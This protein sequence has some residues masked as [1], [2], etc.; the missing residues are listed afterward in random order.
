MSKAPDAFQGMKDLWGFHKEVHEDDWNDGQQLTIKVKNS[1]KS[2][3][4]WISLFFIK[5]RDLI[6]CLDSRIF[7]S[8]MLNKNLFS[9]ELRHYFEIRSPSHWKW[10]KCCR[11]QSNNSKS[12]CWGENHNEQNDWIRRMGCWSKMEKRRKSF[13]WL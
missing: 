2:A 10:S 7:F 13:I 5:K 6:F 4:S 3:V 12:V 1:S 9:I 8:L 11:S